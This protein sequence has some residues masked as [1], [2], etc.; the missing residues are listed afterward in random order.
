MMARIVGGRKSHYL[1]WPWMIS[2]RRY[3]GKAFK[4]KCGATL[5]NQLWAITAAHCVDGKM[6]NEVVLRLGEYNF[7]RMDESHPHVER[8]IYMIVIHPQFDAVTY[9]NDLALLRFYEPVSLRANIVPICLPKPLD[10]V[11]GR[12]AVVTGWGRLAEE[13]E[14]PGSL[15]E[16]SMPILTNK[17]CEE[18]YSAAGYVETI[19]DVFVCAGLLNGGLD[20]CEGDSGG[21]MVVRGTR[22]QWK[23]VGL[24]SWGMGCAAPKQPGVYTRITKFVDWIDDIISL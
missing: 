21:P 8:R 22:G 7:H 20:A 10:D 3:E 9:E 13:G 4:H 24:I 12:M 19:R 23:L 17:E 5:L 14:L 18:M 16:V 15:H 11:A 1:R 6:P 2:L